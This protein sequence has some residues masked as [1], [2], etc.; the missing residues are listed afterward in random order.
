MSTFTP[1]SVWEFETVNRVK[2]GTG[3]SEELP[4][5]LEGFDADS[6]LLITDS[7]L[8]NLGLVDQL[9][10]T[11]G[12]DLET[13]VFT[14]V[15]PDPSKEVFA[16][17]VARARD[18]QPDALVAL[19]GGS[20][21]DVTKTTS[22]LFGVDGEILDY[23]AP[24]TGEGK[25]ITEKAVP[26]VAIPT[27]SGTGSET[28]PVSVISLP[29]Q[30]LKVGISSRYQY[31]DTALIDPGL[32]VSLPPAVTASSGVDAL[33]HAIEAYTTRRF[34]AKPRPETPAER[35]DYNGRNLVTDQF[36]RSA[37]ELIADNLR[38]AVNNGADIEA[39]R[40][41]ALASFMAG[42]A[43]TNAGLGAAHAMAMTV[44]AEFD[45]PHGATVAAVLPDVIRFNATACPDRYRNVAELLGEDV[46]GLDRDVAARKAA[47]GVEKLVSDVDLPTGLAE[48]GITAAAV[49]DLATKTQKME[50]LL[51]GNSRRTDEAALE[52]LYRDAL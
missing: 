31:P 32:T 28:S 14:G 15:E 42:V 22:V 39:R 19:G 3:A 2:F 6:V 20:A 26:T 24:P 8:E 18:V 29:E 34:D 36:A 4:E 51:A 45:S 16:N 40:N 11:L 1:E 27:T 25:S 12:T 47:D 41:M 9:L 50:R 43:F 30:D 23:V 35:P 13:H 5:V 37:I 21:I 17:A 52:E 48:L 46:D 44:G 49:P 33:T 7:E 38:T 10:A